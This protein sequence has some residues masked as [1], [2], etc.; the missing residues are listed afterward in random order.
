MRVPFRS[1]EQRRGKHSGGTESDYQ[2]EDPGQYGERNVP[3]STGSDL[4]PIGSASEAAPRAEPV[5]EP[6]QLNGELGPANHSVEEWDSGV[7]EVDKNVTPLPDA[8]DD[9]SLDPSPRIAP[10]AKTAPGA[11]ATTDSAATTVSSA[12]AS[13]AAAAST[14]PLE[15]DEERGVTIPAA[16]STVSENGDRNARSAEDTHREA[17][18]ASLASAT[19]PTTSTESRP[20]IKLPR[21]I[22][23]ANQ[24]GGVGKTTTAVN[25]GAG[26]AEIG[27]RVLVIDLD[28]QG[29]ATTGLGIDARNFE[30]SMYDVI[31]KDVAL[32]DCIEPTSSE[33]PVRRPCDDRPRWSRDRAGPVRSAGSSSFVRRSG[34]L[35]TTSTTC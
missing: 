13:V 9:Q 11:S 20:A 8:E 1:R 3:G 19:L 25:L 21:V 15:T 2:E 16:A 26:L 7:Y 30:N 17:A 35:S 32:D 12:P 27:F 23:V 31:M 14:T 24:K 4:G 29:N 5:V 33:E 34:P 28:P 22:A 6:A 10:V 18:K